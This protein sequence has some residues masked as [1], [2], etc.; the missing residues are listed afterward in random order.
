MPDKLYH[1]TNIEALAL[2]L[3][4][5]TIKFNPLNKMDDTQEMESSDYQNFGKICYV[6]S[7]TDIEKEEIPMWRMYCNKESGVRISLPV[8]PFEKY[9]DMEYA[10]TH[11]LTTLKLKEGSKKPFTI[12]PFKEMLEKK[13]CLFD[14]HGDLMVTRVKYDNRNEKL[15]PKLYHQI[16]DFN[17]LNIAELGLYKSTYWEFQREWRYRLFPA[18]VDLQCALIC[19]EFVAQL[20]RKIEENNLNFLFDSLFLKIRKECFEKME[21]LMSPN[22][23]PGYQIIIESLVKE[24][25]PCATLHESALKGL[26]Q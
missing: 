4:N 18:P 23:S 20:R 21:I 10:I 13:F 5:Q 7:W 25:N 24:Y 22:I 12:I 3:K 16:G 17:N 26:I 15:Y 19:G 6:S 2:I 9:N 1:Y 8:N 11:G 14:V